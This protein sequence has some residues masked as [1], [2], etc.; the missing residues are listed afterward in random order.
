ME[1]QNSKPG[2]TYRPKRINELHSNFLPLIFFVKFFSQRSLARSIGIFI[3]AG[4]P[5]FVRRDRLVIVEFPTDG[6]PIS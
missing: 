5:R 1:N 2:I 4:K 3:E 6:I